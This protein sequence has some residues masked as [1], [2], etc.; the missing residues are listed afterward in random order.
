[1]P[2]PPALP[3]AS[4]A[5][6]HAGQAVPRLLESQLVHIHSSVYA[7]PTQAAKKEH[8]VFTI[9]HE[10]GGTITDQL[11]SAHFVAVSDDNTHLDPALAHVPGELVRHDPFVAMRNAGAFP[12]LKRFTH[13]EQGREYCEYVMSIIA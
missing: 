8:L 4:V 5:S 10:L 3:P 9:T 7:R 6:L 11:A 1:M 2:A 13:W 12:D